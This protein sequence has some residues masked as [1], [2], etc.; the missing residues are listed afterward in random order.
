MV[1]TAGCSESFIGCRSEA[2]ALREWKGTWNVTGAHTGAWQDG[3]WSNTVQYLALG[4]ELRRPGSGREPHGHAR[5]QD[6]WTSVLARESAGLP[7]FVPLGNLLALH[8]RQAVHVRSC[9]ATEILAESPAQ[10]RLDARHT[11]SCVVLP[12]HSSGQRVR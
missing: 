8:G 7:L 9:V 5:A 11:A 12:T 2:S 4:Q 6:G 1:G 3:C 10:A